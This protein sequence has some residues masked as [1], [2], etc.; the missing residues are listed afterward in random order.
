MKSLGFGVEQ[1]GQD[2]TSGVTQRGQDTNRQTAIDELLLKA[3]ISKA[4]LEAG[5]DTT[6][7]N[8]L[9]QIINGEQGNA[10]NTNTLLSLLTQLMGIPTTENIVTNDPGS[11]G[12]LP[13]I[14]GAAGDV[15]GGFASK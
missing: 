4:D 14:I 15:A 5:L 13:A 12:L 9:T 1:R 7:L 10:N 3:G 6:K 11:A 2:V 8:T